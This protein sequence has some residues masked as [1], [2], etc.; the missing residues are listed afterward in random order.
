M[1]QQGRLD[2]WIDDRG[3]GFITPDDG[4]ARLFAHIRDFG[5]RGRPSAGDRVHFVRG[6][7]DRG[8]PRARTFGLSAD[9]SRNRP[10]RRTGPVGRRGG[11]RAALALA[12]PL[13]LAGLAAAGRLPFALALLSAALC[14]I[15]Y[16]AYARDKSAALNGRGRTPENTLHLLDLLGGW[17]GGL[18]A[19][20]RLRH[21][22][23]KRSFQVVFWLTVLAHVVAVAWLASPEGRAWWL[24]AVG[25]A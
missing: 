6:A 2:E 8:R 5:S 20:R 17:P 3:Y 16:L 19:Q 22:S 12:W 21:K 15:S 18:L 4:G 9:T 23:S 14:A 24:V 1:R 7:D 25:A 10:S 13:L 11:S